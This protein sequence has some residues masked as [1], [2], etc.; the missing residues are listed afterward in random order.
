MESVGLRVKNGADIY[1]S[2]CFCHMIYQGNI[3]K[4]NPLCCLEVIKRFVVVAGVETSVEKKI[5]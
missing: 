3:P 2:F 5:D 4:S 1:L